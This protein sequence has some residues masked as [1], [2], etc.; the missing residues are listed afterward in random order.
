[1]LIIK[2]FGR[3]VGGSL[4]HGHQQ[5]I[6]SNVKPRHLERN[7]RF[8]QERGETFAA[9]MLRENPAELTV[10]D[11]GPAMLMVPYFMRRPYNM[12]LVLKDHRKRFL[13]ECSEEELAALAQ[14]WGEITG[15]IMAIMPAIGKTTAYNVTVSNGPGAGLYCDFLPYTQETGGFEH[16][17]LWV[18]QDSPERAAP[19]LR[20]VLAATSDPSAEEHAPADQRADK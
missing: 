15:A 17:G 9:Y 20:Q 18:C 12:L 19:R 11:Y 13:C 4:A 5:I 3:L 8:E 2:N 16:L 1:V 6:Y 7:E 14:A 10:K